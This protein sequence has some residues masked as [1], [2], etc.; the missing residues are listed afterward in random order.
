[1]TEDEY[2]LQKDELLRHREADLISEEDYL[3]AMNDL[4]VERNKD[5]SFNHENH[6]HG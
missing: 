6:A 4:E 5:F 3:K 1:M 2:E